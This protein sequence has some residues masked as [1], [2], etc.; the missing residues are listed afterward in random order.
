[1]KRIG[2]TVENQFLCTLLLARRFLPAAHSHRLGSLA[3]LI[4]ASYGENAH[5]A[6]ADAE[7]AAHLWI[8]LHGRICK[9]MEQIEVNTDVLQR[10]C[11]KPKHAVDR[12][13]ASLR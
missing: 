13:I 7:V 4:G 12:F 5:R 6:L 8:F 11:K 2:A 3:G 10:V 1:M 9:R